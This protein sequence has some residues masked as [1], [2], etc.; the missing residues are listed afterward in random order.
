[1]PATTTT[2]T[3]PPLDIGVQPAAVSGLNFQDFSIP[4]SLSTANWTKQAK[5]YAQQTFLGASITSFNMNGGFGDTSSSLTVELIVD[6]YNKSDEKGY[7]LGDD[8][9]HNGKADKFSPPVAGCP[10]FFKFG[11]NY[12]TVQ[13]AFLKTY[14]EMFDY[15]STTTTTTTTTAAPGSEPP[16][17]EI[18]QFDPV[19]ELLNE[20]GE[21]AS[22]GLSYDKNYP[23]SEIPEGTVLNTETRAL[24][25]DESSEQSTFGI[26]HRGLDHLVFGGILQSYTENRST[27]G[28]PVYSVQVKDPREI[29]SNCYL[30]LNNYTG[31]TFDN[32]N[33]FNIF[34][35][36]EYNPSQETIEEL[37]EAYGPPTTNKSILKKVFQ[38]DK[39]SYEGDIDPNKKD[40]WFKTEQPAGD[41]NPLPQ[42]DINDFADTFPVTGTGFSRRGSQGM[43]YYRIKDALYA[44][45][46]YFG[47]LPDEY[48]CQG[49]GGMI[50]FRGFNYIVDFSG[51]PEIP[52]MYYFDFD[53]INI[54]DFAM[55]ICDVA[56][57]DL[58]VSLV[59]VINHEKTAFLHA[60]NSSIIEKTSGQSQASK[61]ASID[62][63]VSDHYG[64]DECTSSY[65]LV[66]GIIRLEA[67]DR[68]KQPKYGAIKEYLDNLEKDEIYVENRDVGY[69]LS[70][71]TT[72]KFLVGAQTVDNYLF[73]TSY[74][75]QLE[76][77]KYESQFDLWKIINTQQVIPYYGKLGKLA[78]TIPKGFGSYQQIL[79]DTTGLNANGVGN[80]YVATELELRAAIIGYDRWKEFLLEY[81]DK[82][83]EALTELDPITGK[84]VAT[85]GGESS[86]PTNQDIA[87]LPIHPDLAEEGDDV[88]FV[89]VPRSLWPSDKQAGIN[90]N[91]DHETEDF[92]D[93]FDKKTKLPTN[94]CN[95]PYGWPLYYKRATQLGIP[96]A[97]FTTIS[98]KSV[99]ILTKLADFDP[100]EINE[101]NYKIILNDIW[102]N[103]V[104]IYG[105]PNNV[106][107]EKLKEQI[108]SIK[109]IIE[110]GFDKN[111]VDLSIGLITGAREQ[112]AKTLNALPRIAKKSN[113]NAMEVHKFLQS[114]ANECLGKKFLV[115][116]PQRV[117]TKYTTSDVEYFAKTD[118]NSSGVQY[119]SA[120]QNGQIGP[121]GF[122]PRPKASGVGFEFSYN[123]VE[124]YKEEEEYSHLESNRDEQKIKDGID[125]DPENPLSIYAGALEGNYNPISDANEFNYTP[126]NLGGF[127]DFDL[128]SNIQGFVRS[129][130]E[131]IV[132]CQTS[133]LGLDEDE[134]KSKGRYNNNNLPN[135]IKLKLVPIDMTYLINEQNRVS[136]YVRF[137]NSQHLDLSNLNKDTFTQ[138]IISNDG[139]MIANFDE[140][141][142]NTQEE[143]TS[144][145]SVGDC[146]KKFKKKE[147]NDKAEDTK[148]DDASVAFVK[149][150]VDESLYMPPKL[151]YMYYGVYGDKVVDNGKIV[152]PMKAW[153]KKDK[154]FVTLPSYREA[155]FHPVI[156]ETLSKRRYVWDFER[157]KSCELR[158]NIIDPIIT[159]L[160]LEN[161]YALITLPARIMP[162]KDARFLDSEFQ[163]QKPESLKH[164]LTA[165]VI[166]H[167]HFSDP[168]YAKGGFP[169]T[170]SDAECTPADQGGDGPSKM[171]PNDAYK[172]AVDSLTFALPQLIQFTSP[173]PVY[174]NIISIPMISRDR[175]YGPWVSSQTDVKAKAYSNI[176]GRIEFMK[177]ENLAPWNYGGY[178]LMNDIAKLQVSFS[179]SLLLFSE[180]GGFVVPAPPSGV[181]LGA[182]LNAQGPLISNISTSVSTGG[183][184]TTYQFDLY[185]A[186]FGK[187]H[188]QKEQQIARVSREK[189]KLRDEKNGLLRKGLG[190]GTHN[191]NYLNIQN[192]LTAG[193]DESMPKLDGESMTNIVA[194]VQANRQKRKDTNGNTVIVK[195]TNVAVTN[196]TNEAIGSVAE[197]FGSTQQAQSAMYNSAGGD[198]S[199][200]FTPVSLNIYHPNMPSK[201]D[202]FQEARQSLYPSIVDIND[203]N[204]LTFYE[205]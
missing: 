78:V 155:N 40:V 5:G 178:S 2:T 6:E 3:N 198:M 54:L 43:P 127:F 28:N 124:H 122:I 41:E 107:D 147:K 101:D 64:L 97:G 25:V 130:L 7:G 167:N 204:D 176:G 162:R 36:L 153:N 33:L 19:S 163:L 88:Y 45:F 190:K 26:T 65:E 168:P 121:F 175:C 104:E 116:I 35:F 37:V 194:S 59:P 103:L 32:D 81:N 186:S 73:Q 87:K 18:T 181:S 96:E 156:S 31:T 4:E 83:M 129:D 112:A 89:T 149:C 125:L 55:E 165:D 8:V 205:A 173:S 158:G 80:Y 189:E 109:K 57:H 170:R 171:T 66:A 164:F 27:G 70:N 191:I 135:A 16:D 12:A 111:V 56:S 119:N 179:N 199:Q 71:V 126:T 160:D 188:K 93:I 21:L 77:E 86:A 150:S 169:T 195:E 38:N 154:K 92:D 68:S 74:D 75:R 39:I 201:H 20:N 145:I 113:N 29:L 30:I 99:Q 182:E 139:T 180:R 123:F 144:N 196:T 53:Q 98:G 50:N 131:G 140:D 72:D 10:V 24:I 143:D 60:R 137:D 115:K 11:S 132:S 174:P 108:E 84:L 63:P 146:A 185:T 34:G 193:L 15:T 61:Q 67:V 133:G 138:Q 106:T 118:I 172:K 91:K 102:A 151:T 94:T 161:C 1:M 159:E 152:K 177:D 183:I 14:N 49:F 148:D 192:D 82:Y 157:K 52:D 85:H 142:D 141:L 17:Q 110:E 166:K 47:K 105:D 48:I 114:V 62:R 69:E 44:M 197:N 79:L 58:Y 95:P 136:P 134:E 120:K 187:L 90:N 42:A 100:E 46:E 76:R 117:N 184:H 202:P 13:E 22:S 51:L 9:Y 200:T 203:N 23:F 128:Y